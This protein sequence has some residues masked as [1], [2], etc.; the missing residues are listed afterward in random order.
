L[1][2]MFVVAE[3]QHLDLMFQVLLF[4]SSLGAILLGEFLF[5]TPEASLALFCGVYC[6]KYVLELV[7]AYRFCSSRK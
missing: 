4:L 6:F 1:S 2:V 7:L 5:G 3:K